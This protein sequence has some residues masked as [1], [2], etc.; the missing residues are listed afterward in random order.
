MMFR[1]SSPAE[2]KVQIPNLTG[3]KDLIKSVQHLIENG[4]Y[5]SVIERHISFPA[6]RA[7]IVDLMK[8]YGKKEEDRLKRTWR[9]VN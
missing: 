6:L 1:E 9:P 4:E 5:R 3:L 8:E 7:L 2:E